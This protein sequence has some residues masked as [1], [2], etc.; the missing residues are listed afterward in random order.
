MAD[1]LAV[2]KENENLKGWIAALKWVKEKK[3]MEETE[4]KPKVKL[5][6]RNGN[7]FA[8]MGEVKK[9]LVKEGMKDLVPQFIKEATAGDYNNLL[10]VVSEYCEIE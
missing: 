1:S 5:V 7:A 4:Y 2:I 3:I 8:I 6:G 9:V 10:A